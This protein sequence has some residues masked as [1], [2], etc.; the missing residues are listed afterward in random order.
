MKTHEALC[1]IVTII[2]LLV[3]F[4]NANLKYTY[5][6]HFRFSSTKVATKSTNI[7]PCTRYEIPQNFGSLIT[8]LV[9]W[10]S[11]GVLLLLLL[12]QCK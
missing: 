7:V 10:V 4:T 9:G 6:D 2:I 3:M 1:V 8:D 12:I 11:K 5:S